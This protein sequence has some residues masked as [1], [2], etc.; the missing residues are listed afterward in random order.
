MSLVLY[1]PYE[2]PSLTL[3]KEQINNLRVQLL[4][5]KRETEI[6][7]S[8][9]QRECST[10]LADALKG[11]LYLSESVYK[12]DK[13]VV[14]WYEKGKVLRIV[15]KPLGVNKKTSAIIQRK[16]TKLKTQ[17]TYVEAQFA[18]TSQV[19]QEALKDVQTLNRRV[20]DYSKTGIGSAQENASTTMKSFEEEKKLVDVKLKEKEVECARVNANILDTD[21]GV[22]RTRA[23]TDKAEQASD[24]AST[25]SLGLEDFDEA[26][27]NYFRRPRCLV[28]GV[29]LPLEHLP[30]SVLLLPL[31]LELLQEVRLL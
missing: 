12:A 14:F 15:L 27:S 18:S 1:S 30:S 24:K 26:L 22:A 6:L 28:S 3:L 2:E 21:E 13:Q 17:A 7:N 20:N 19:C 5:L 9:Y 16:T 8:D 10:S 25:V 4:Q 31:R 11:L 23:A 29:R